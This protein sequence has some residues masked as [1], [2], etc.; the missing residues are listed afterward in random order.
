MKV[1]DGDAC[2]EYFSACFA[3]AKGEVRVLLFRNPAGQCFHRAACAATGFSRQGEGQ[4]RHCCGI[5]RDVARASSKQCW[6]SATWRAASK[7]C[8]GHAN[9]G[10]SAF[11][12]YGLPNFTCSQRHGLGWFPQRETGVTLSIQWMLGKSQGGACY[13]RR[14]GRGGG[15]C[16]VDSDAVFIGRSSA[17]ATCAC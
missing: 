10:A 15:G 4:S 17:S 7:A 9:R 12:R 11:P 1:V 5:E 13:S 16:I 3:A 8:L 6:K 14:K 2:D